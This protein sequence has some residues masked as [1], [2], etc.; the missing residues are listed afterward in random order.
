MT[1]GFAVEDAPS[2]KGKSGVAHAV[3]LYAYNKMNQ[4]ILIDVKGAEAEIDDAEVT[5]TLI[6]VLDIS[7]TIAI[8][9]GIPAVSKR[10]RAMA[11]A[12][13]IAVITGK[14][15]NDIIPQVDAILSKYISRAASP[16]NKP[17]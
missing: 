13:N 4:T 10:A 1:Y 7:P 9:I 11:A 3:N 8:L 12:Q 6:K 15:A 16:V 2:I 5:S 17:E 14:S